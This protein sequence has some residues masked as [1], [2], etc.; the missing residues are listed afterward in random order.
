M[1]IKF[2]CDQ[3]ANEVVAECNGPIP[4]APVLP[5]GWTMIVVV[6]EG[7]HEPKHFESAQAMEDWQA[8]Q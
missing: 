1:A 7:Q 5:D 4:Y 6:N 2:V 8:A 3:T